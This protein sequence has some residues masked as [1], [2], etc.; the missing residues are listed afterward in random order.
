MPNLVTLLNTPLPGKE[1]EEEEVS[2]EALAVTRAQ[3]GREAKEASVLEQSEA[4]SGV[5]PRA[6]DSTEL[7]EE[8]REE[9]GVAPIG[10]EFNDDIFK[11]VKERKRQTRWEK[12]QQ[13]QEFATAAGQKNMEHPLD[14]VGA[15]ELQKR[16][17]DETLTTVRQAADGETNAAG[18][19]F[20]RKNGIIYRR[21]IPPGREVETMVVNQL[22]LPSSYRATVLRFTHQI[23]LAGYLGKNK[24]AERIRQRLYWPTLFHD[25]DDFCRSCEVCQRCSPKRG[26]HTLMVP[27]P[28]IE[29]P[30]Q[31]I[32]MDIVGP[33][34]R[35]R[36]GN[37]FILVI[38]DYVTRYPE[39]FALKSVDT[40]HVAKALISLFSRMGVPKEILTDQGT[41]F[42]S[43]LLAELYRLLHVKAV[44]TSPYHPQTD[45]LV[46]RFNRTLK[47]M[48]RK[49]VDKEGKD[50]DKLLPY[51]LFAYREVP[52]SS[53]GFF[54]LELIYGRAVRGPLDILRESWEAGEKSDESIVSHILSVQE[55]LTKMTEL[56]SENTA[57]AKAQ[58]KT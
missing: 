17:K 2:E 54:P 46:E 49:T 43:K 7:E 30:F 35:S 1:S 4:A 34:P 53:T 48:L 25:V 44:K 45:G 23:P 28:V 9:I 26:P 55:K 29:E 15:E 13:R 12:R 5:Q 10:A 41:N 42:A 36:S 37:K 58:Q 51:V 14:Y 31:R 56:A 11:V 27:L 20:F 40:E 32:A 24:T 50:W 57:R 16:H 33:L 8:D 6:L 39:A 22:V 19:G 3:A 18:G 47:G 52:Q 21:W 38:C